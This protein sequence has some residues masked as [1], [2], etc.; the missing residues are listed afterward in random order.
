MRNLF[1]G[2]LVGLM[3]LGAGCGMA[4]EEQLGDASETRTESTAQALTTTYTLSW[5]SN[6]SATG[7]VCRFGDTSLGHQ[8]ATNTYASGRLEQPITISGLAGRRITSI[9]LNGSSTTF[10]YDD[11][12]VLAYNKHLVMA[13]DKRVAEYSALTTSLGTSP[14]LY[15]WPNIR[16]KLIDNQAAQS[17][18]CTS[19]ASTCTVPRTEQTGTMNV[20]VSAFKAV[21]EA[22]YPGA[23]ASRTFTL[24]TM[25]D[26]DASLDCRHGAVT[27]TLT[28]VHEPAVE[29]CDGLDN[30]AD[31]VVDDG[32]GCVQ[33]IHRAYNPTNGFHLYT[34]NL[35][36]TT[37]NG[38]QLEYQNFFYLSKT[39]V[40]GTTPFYYCKAPDGAPHFFYTTQ[41]TCEL[42]APSTPSFHIGH[43]A[44]TQ[45]PGTVPL[46]RLFST[47]TGDHFYTTNYTESRNVLA[48][49]GWQDEGI[50]GY[51]WSTP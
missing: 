26:N 35:S 4:P 7:D 1:R 31:G 40:P 3:A 9:Q 50:A 41:A 38:Y 12:M 14:V 17:A 16:N 15:S 20:N 49:S 2:T 30:D 24:A 22:A 34:P 21:D 32:A 6:L 5:A 28:V 11:V 33:G 36:E 46:Y 48:V 43:I 51:V 44:P 27:L 47:V 23:P 19:G 37:A 25:G 42:F 39:Q 8:A 45:L 10:K 13:S 29:K 18:W